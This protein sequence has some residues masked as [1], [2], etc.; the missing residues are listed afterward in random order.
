[1]VV[2]PG[3]VLMYTSSGEDDGAIAIRLGLGLRDDTMRRRLLFLLPFVECGCGCGCDAAVAAPF[4]FEEDNE[5]EEE[6]EEDDGETSRRRRWCCP[7]ARFERIADRPISS[8]MV[9]FK[10]YYWLIKKIY[11]S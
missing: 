2:V 1:M 3:L 6:D 4:R 5:E 9:V 7:L 10:Y 8:S 11:S